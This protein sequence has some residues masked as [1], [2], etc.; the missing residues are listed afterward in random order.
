MHD[1]GF[2]RDVLPLPMGAGL[3]LHLHGARHFASTAA[4]AKK[5]RQLRRQEVWLREGRV[6]ALSTS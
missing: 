1:P 5:G 4:G 6:Y 2:T 3:D